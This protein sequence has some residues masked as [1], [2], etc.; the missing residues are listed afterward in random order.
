[1]T[2]A[3]NINPANSNVREILARLLL[4]VDL[5]VKGFKKSVFRRVNSNA[6][7]S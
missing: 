5:G 1:M 2:Y 7:Y 4:F 3:L 6:R